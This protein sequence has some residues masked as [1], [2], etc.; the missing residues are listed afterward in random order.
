MTFLFNPFI[1]VDGSN[2]RRYGGA[3]LGLTLCKRLVELM[4]GTI[5]VESSEGHGS[6]FRLLIPFA[7][8]EEQERS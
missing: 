7:L 6:M 2:T 4:R 8:M 3:G 5:R 1:Q